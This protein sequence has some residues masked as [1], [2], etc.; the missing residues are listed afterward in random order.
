[1]ELYNFNCKLPA[2]RPWFIVVHLS[3]CSGRTNEAVWSAASGSVG[4]YAVLPGS[5]GADA[6]LSAVTSRGL[7]GSGRM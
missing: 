3:Q 6:S 7:G 5:E 2:H 1:M 4:E